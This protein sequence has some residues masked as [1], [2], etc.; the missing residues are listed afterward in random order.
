M[1]CYAIVKVGKD[2]VVQV[3][4]RGVLKFTSRR[5]AARLVAVATG[6]LRDAEAADRAGPSISRDGADP[7]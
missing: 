5:R 7:A 6:L 4:R 1:D 2:Y 3:N